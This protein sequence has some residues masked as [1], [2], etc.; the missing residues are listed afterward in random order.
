MLN[1][2][3]KKGIRIEIQRRIE[4]SRTEPDEHGQ[5]LKWPPNIRAKYFF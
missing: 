2:L 3:D 5:S 1:S 4:V